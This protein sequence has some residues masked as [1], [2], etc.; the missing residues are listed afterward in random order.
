MW[1]ERTTGPRI[2]GCSGY[3]QSEM[4]RSHTEQQ[5]YAVIGL[6]HV[7]LKVL[8]GTATGEVSCTLSEGPTTTMPCL[9][10]GSLL[11]SQLPQAQTAHL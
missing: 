7:F 4:C 11:H 1:L 2:R 9:S 10:E 6:T 8:R 5:K 3:R